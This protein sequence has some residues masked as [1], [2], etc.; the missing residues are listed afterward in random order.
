MGLHVGDDPINVHKNRETLRNALGSEK[1]LFMNQVHGDTVVC[2][3]EDTPTPTCDAMISQSK[4][5]ALAVMVA[6]C[7]PLLLY[8]APTQSIG[9][10]HAGRVGSALSISVKTVQAMQKHFGVDPKTLKIYIGPSIGACCY[11]VGKE[12]CGGLEHVLHV[13]QNAFFLD[14]PK[15]NIQALCEAGVLAENI[16]YKALC[17]CCLPNYFSYRREKITGRFAGV[18]RL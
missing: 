11:E 3:D 6:D 14:L 10:V 16:E 15:A 5:V 12:V 4:N 7:I 18:I 13:K 1:L 2:V 17:T 8:D 9:V